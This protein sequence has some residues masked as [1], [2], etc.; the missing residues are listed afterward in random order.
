MNYLKNIA[1]G[2]LITFSTLDPAPDISAATTIEYIFSGI[3]ED[4]STIC[5]SWRGIK[6]IQDME[7]LYQEKLYKLE[8]C[9]PA[10]WQTNDSKFI[11]EIG[12]IDP[13]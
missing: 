6:H 10:P 8:W 7:M 9:E 12:S 2:E 3:Y 5:K 13:I 11:L 4:S 1:T